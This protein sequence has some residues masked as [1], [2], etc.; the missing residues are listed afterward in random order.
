MNNIWW[1]QSTHING[2][3]DIFLNKL[4]KQIQILGQC[5]YLSYDIHYC[6]ISH[7][8]GVTNVMSLEHLVTLG[9]EISEEPKE[10]KGYN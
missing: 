4:Q 9:A 10:S 8:G 7:S 6:R 3:L 1:V 5:L 2:S